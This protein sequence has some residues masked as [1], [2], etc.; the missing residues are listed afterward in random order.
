MSKSSYQVIDTLRWSIE[1]KKPKKKSKIIGGKNIEGECFEPVE[2]FDEGQNGKLKMAILT[3][4]K[5]MGIVLVHFRF[6][7][8][9]VG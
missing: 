5:E 7:F 6:N 3:L 8:R 1:G 2:S 4:E 9:S